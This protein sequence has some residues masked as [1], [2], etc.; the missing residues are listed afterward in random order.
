MKQLDFGRMWIFVLLSTLCI[1]VPLRTAQAQCSGADVIIGTETG[2]TPTIE[3]FWDFAV[4]A[5]NVIF[6]TTNGSITA[7]HTLRIGPNAFVSANNSGTCSVDHPTNTAGF[8]INKTGILKLEDDLV[9][10]GGGEIKTLF[11]NV[12]GPSAGE[13]AVGG[14][15]I[16]Q[17][18]FVFPSQSAT[19]QPVNIQSALVNPVGIIVMDIAD[20]T[21]DVVIANSVYQVKIGA[22][23]ENY[24]DILSGDV[25]LSNTKLT[26]DF[27]AGFSASAGDEFTLMKIGGTRTGLLTRSNGTALAEGDTVTVNG[28]NL[29]ITYAGGVSGK[30]IMLVAGSAN[31][32]PTI[33]AIANQT[34]NEDAAMGPLAFTVGD[35]ETPDA[36]T[37]TAASSNTTLLPLS[38]ITLGGSGSDRTVTLSPALNQNGSAIVTLTVSDGELTN[39]TQFTLTVTAVNDAPTISSIANQTTNEDTA[40]G[41]LAF[42]VDD[43]ET[44]NSLTVTRSSSNTTLLPLSG[45]VLGGSGTSRT[46]TLTPALNQNGSAV[47]TLTV[48]DGTLTNTSQFTLTVTAVND[49]PVAQNQS[50]TTSFNTAKAI[51]L[52][53]TDVEGSALIYSAV[54]SPAHGT[55]SGTAPNLTYTPATNYSGADSFTF[56][57]NDGAANSNLA[58]VNITVQTGPAITSFTPTSGT[59][60]TVVTISGVN[61]TGA[62]QV[63]F[64]GTAATFTVNSNTQITATAPNGVTT[65]K[66]SVTTADG[67]ATSA[68]DFVVSVSGAPSVSINDVTLTEGDSGTANATFT[69]TLS[70]ASSQTI[71]INAIPSNGSARA[72]GDYTS[73]GIR[74]VYDPGELSHTF[75]VPVNGDLLNEI[76][77]TFFVILSSP[78]NCS[79]GRGRGV[80][81]ILDNDPVP[82]ITIDN[83]SIG[84]GNT[85]QR[86]ASF[87]LK[88][89]APSGQLVKATFSTADGTATAGNDYVAVAPTQIAFTTGNSFAYARVLINGDVLNEQNE[90]FFVNLASPVAATIADDQALGTILNDD[91]APSLTVNNVSI[92]EGNSGTKNLAFTV[93]LSAASGQTVTVNVATADGSARS[94]SDY[95]AK[96]SVISFTPGTA[97]TRTVNVVING[98]TLIEG[99]EALFLLLSAVTNATIG[100][101]RGIGTILNDD[102]TG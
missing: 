93:S 62:T 48:S 44:P 59:A 88:L 36:L 78:V 18:N 17:G 85:G 69:I 76:T 27:P 15:L 94:T 56:R 57:A 45:I 65:G 100:T 14:K 20:A 81:T 82:S 60:G 51:T 73:G 5:G 8:T 38:S 33:S 68:A 77:E 61:F 80:G 32:A 52:S 86:V 16:G 40:K 6:G 70:K 43:V 22:G 12:I 87:R 24:L 99:D 53:A 25:Q 1:L 35:A 101:G 21:D 50:V 75:S 11:L 26:I 13:A 91:R 41:P 95:V 58:T 39:D 2:G 42:T 10:S 97:L 55:L 46:V 49:A 54:T 89:S 19:T 29:Q 47:V 74:L 64:N 96:N 23:L 28:V 63:K 71:S 90:T 31:T 9:N 66:I 37:V 30:D 102:N 84:E 98:D 3:E 67:T 34:T 7:T 92:T 4:Q 72:P 79:I 83:V